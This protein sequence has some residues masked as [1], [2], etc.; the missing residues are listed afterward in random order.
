MMS[1]LSVAI[2]AAFI[3]GVAFLGLAW[4]QA[5]SPKPLP[6]LRLVIPALEQTKAAEESPAARATPT[7]ATGD[8][9][10]NQSEY[11]EAFELSEE[12]R[13]RMDGAMQDVQEKTMESIRA[14][15]AARERFYQAVRNRDWAAARAATDEWERAFAA[16][17]GV[18]NRAKIAVLELLTPAQH[19]KLFR[20]HTYLLD[21]PWTVGRR[22][23]VHRGT[24]GTPP[25][26]PAAVR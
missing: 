22:I 25:A 2:T 20:E 6:T 9:W 5:Q 21:R 13:R 16:Q 15:N 3:V 1:K 14:Q 4:A 24:P 19:E 23:Q 7:L 11:I 10:W 8:Y 26:T 12:Q 18:A 17:W